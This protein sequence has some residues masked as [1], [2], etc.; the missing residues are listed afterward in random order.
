M[1]FYCRIVCVLIASL[2]A[3]HALSQDLSGWSDKTLCRLASSQQDDPQYLQE[4]KNRG[5][6]CG[7]GSA[8]VVVSG[9]KTESSIIGQSIYKTITKGDADIYQ[10]QMLLNRF[11][12]D[13]G[14]PNGQWTSVTRSAIR[15]FY[16]ELG[17][18]FSGKWS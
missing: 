1:N 18:S 17:Q 9:N 11:R 2:M 14:S 7:G 13:V 15:K 16:Q 4:A 8:A 10:A 6:N 3:T 5:L 12:Y